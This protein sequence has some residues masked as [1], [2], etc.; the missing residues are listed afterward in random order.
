[1]GNVITGWIFAR[2]SGQGLALLPD[3][4]QRPEIKKLFTIEVDQIK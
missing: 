2:I 1:L 4:Q 3:D